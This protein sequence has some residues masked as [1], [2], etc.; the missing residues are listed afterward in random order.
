MALAVAYV[1]P[2]AGRGAGAGVAAAGGVILAGGVAAT[3]GGGGGGGFFAGKD[4]SV[5]PMSDRSIG[6]GEGHIPPDACWGEGL[7]QQ[8]LHL[9]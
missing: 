3:G 8:R 1:A 9:Q 6:V 2:R 5:L 4:P 7:A